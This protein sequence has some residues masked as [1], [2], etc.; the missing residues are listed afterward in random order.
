[1]SK[2]LGVDI[3]GVLTN[4]QDYVFE[5][6]S[7]FAY[8]RGEDLTEMRKYAYHSAGIFNWNEKVDENFWYYILEQYSKDERPRILASEVLYKLKEDGWKIFL[9][10]ARSSLKEE[11]IQ[12]KKIEGILENWLKEHDIPYD[13]L[14]FAGSDKREA[15]KKYNI[16]V[17]IEDS[18]KNIEQLRTI[19]PI[20]VFDA[21]YNKE[22]Q[23]KDYL[24]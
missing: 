21:M 6:G 10:T 9:I 3:D 18:P 17:M 14:D 5:Y 12:N 19:C 23:V 2:N 16:D 1:M 8:E 24:E 20:I 22:C 7:K 11:D 13:V 4:I 15:L